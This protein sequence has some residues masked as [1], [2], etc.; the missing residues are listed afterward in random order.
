M[1]ASSWILHYVN[2]DGQI[3][4]WDPIFSVCIKFGANACNNGQ[5][6]AK[7]CDFESGGRRHLGFCRIRVEG[8]SCPGTLLTVSVSNLVRIRSK[9]DDLWSFNGFQNGGRRHL[10]LLFSNTGPLAKPPSWSEVCAKILFQL[11][12]YF[13][14]YGHLKILHI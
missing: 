8:K 6:M 14:R 7:K 12:Y 5:I 9:I 1:A 2:F 13:P 11:R 4:L 10:E 3:C